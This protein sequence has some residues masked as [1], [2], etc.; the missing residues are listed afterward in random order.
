MKKTIVFSDFGEVLTNSQFSHLVDSSPLPELTRESLEWICMARPLRLRLANEREMA[1]MEQ[2]RTV[3]T[4]NGKVVSGTKKEKPSREE[5]LEHSIRDDEGGLWIIAFYDTRA[6]VKDGLASG[7]L[8]RTGESFK[9]RPFFSVSAGA[10]EGGQSAFFAYPTVTNELLVADDLELLKSMAAAGMGQASSFVDGTEFADLSPFIPDLGQSWQVSV[11][12][13]RN[14]EMMELWK[15]HPEMEQRVNELE[16]QYEKGLQYEITSFEARDTIVDRTIC[17]FGSDEFASRSA[18]EIKQKFLKDK[19]DF[20]Q[21]STF[22]QITIINDNGE[23]YEQ[24]S[25]LLDRLFNRSS[26]LS[27]NKAGKT[28]VFVEDNIVMT[29]FIWGEKELQT[30]RF[31]KNAAEAANSHDQM[32]MQITTQDEKAHHRP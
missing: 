13:S 29:V 5:I 23:V 10:D 31:L 9:G 4:V 1:Q 22:T 7:W 12:R 28:D 19:E 25:G 3:V 15:D 20:K 32:N 14:R 8:S 27:S 24:R 30:L 21:R 17:I 2:A 26:L 6:V 18:E 16:E 11:V